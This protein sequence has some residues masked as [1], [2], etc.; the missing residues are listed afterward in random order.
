MQMYSLNYNTMPT[1]LSCTV[2]ES[3]KAVT[4]CFAPRVLSTI[5]YPTRTRGIIIYLINM[6]FRIARFL[7]CIDLYTQEI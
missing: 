5:P 3:T 6:R 7:S 1:L 2:H 4:G